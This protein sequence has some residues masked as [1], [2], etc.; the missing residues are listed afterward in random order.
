[1]KKNKFIFLV[2]A[3]GCAAAISGLYIL[4]VLEPLELKTLDLRFRQ[5]AKPELADTNV[6]LV[7]IDEKSLREFKRNNIVWK[8]PRDIYA[9]LVNYLHR[10]GAKVV[11]FDVLFTEPDI[12][13]LT[14]DAE[15]TDGAFAEALRK[16]GNVILAC[17]LLHEEDLL[18]ESNPYELRPGFNVIYQGDVNPPTY[19]SALLPIPLFQGVIKGAGVANFRED[20]QDGICRRMPLL[21]RFGEH[22]IPQLGMA[23]YL[24]AENVKTIELLPDRSVK[25]GDLVIPLARDGQFL[26]SWYG[27]GGPNG[28]FRYYSIAALVQSAI[29]EERGVKPLVPSETFRGKYVFVGASAAGLFDSKP[30]PFTVYEPYPGMEIS[31]TLVSNLLNKHFIVRSPVWVALTAVVV[32]S[33]L[34][35][36]LFVVFQKIRDIILVTLAAGAVWV[37]ASLLLF[38]TFTVWL[39][40]IAP[41]AAI[42]A[43]F[44]TAGIVSYQTEGRARRQLRAVF[45]RYLSPA[46]VREIVDQSEAV[47]LG[48]KEI[49]GTA[50]FSDLKD[51]TTISE[52]LKPRDLVTLLNEYFSIAS[53]VVLKNEGM[54]DKYLGDAIMAIFGA[55]VAT[56]RHAILA[57]N[58]AVEVQNVLREQWAAKLDRFPN[59]ETRI[60]INSGLMV[61]GNIGSQ[62]RLD[63]TA[64]GDTVNLASRLEGV[65]KV[66]GTNIL[67][68]EFTYRY[69]ADLFVVRELDALRVKGKKEAVKVYELVGKNEEVPRETISTIRLFEEGLAYYRERKFEGALRTFQTILQKKP[70]DGPAHLY[71]K[72]S[73]HYLA[74]PP[75]ME[76]DGITTLDSK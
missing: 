42:V 39:D 5:F 10:G 16:A 52:Q 4:G 18:S 36:L 44:S 38:D 20:P 76:W 34:I 31:A 62:R 15:Q 50:F 40:V 11:T 64:I 75:P 51:F 29:E 17:Q 21:F 7:A 2:L 37:A 61:V 65:N 41:L 25:A 12:D 68:S 22:T 30:T 6:V 70:N 74:T 19:A 3:A 8:W 14:T 46:V 67:I 35:A 49:T 33:L 71:V 56:E 23:A 48:G 1:M 66:Y 59:L 26:L 28:S 53:D 54:L 43:T 13:R 32:L 72:R 45:N 63:Y 27:R 73:Q 47:E 55:P 9:A 69:V 57:C 58:A 60:G 24:A